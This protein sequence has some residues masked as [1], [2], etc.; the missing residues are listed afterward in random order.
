MG[1]GFFFSLLNQSCLR[2]FGAGCFYLAPGTRTWTAGD[3]RDP[4]GSSAA[5][6][7]AAVRGEGEVCAPSRQAR[8][9]QRGRTVPGVALSGALGRTPS[10]TEL[11]AGWPRNTKINIRNSNR[12]SA[13]LHAT[14]P[15]RPGTPRRRASGWKRAEEPPA[16]FSARPP[17]LQPPRQAPP[18]RRAGRGLPCPARGLGA[19]AGRRRRKRPRRAAVAVAAVAAPPPA[20]QEREAGGPAVMGAEQSA[21]AD[22]HPG[23]PGASGRCLP[24][25]GLG[26]ERPL[27]GGGWE[28]P[29]LGK[30]LPVPRA[31]RGCQREGSVLLPALARRWR[32]MARGG[33][34][35]CG[36]GN[37]FSFFSR[38]QLAAAR[39]FLWG[40]RRARVVRRRVQRAGGGRQ[41][42]Q[43]GCTPEPG[44]GPSPASGPREGRSRVRSSGEGRE[45]GVSGARVSERA[46]TA[47]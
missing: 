38:Q 28:G 1:V 21:E 35:R 15:A 27:A 11:G 24:C 43:G 44:R 39:P 9:E 40:G 42:W 7:G 34:R 30:G 17:R 18:A 16:A 37:G 31:R 20:L 33:G 22:S 3:S 14:A 36:G 12:N 46:D 23:E 29:G 10:T 4:A 19:A 26:G 25:P 2:T 41:S 13:V 45:E 5:D 6:D 8:G 47:F 32:R